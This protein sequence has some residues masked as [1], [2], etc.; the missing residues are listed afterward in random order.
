MNDFARD[1]SGD[2]VFKR[3]MISVVIGGAVFA[4]YMMLY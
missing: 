2:D 1:Y 4:A 3:I